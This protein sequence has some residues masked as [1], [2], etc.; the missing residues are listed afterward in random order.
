MGQLNRVSPFK[1]VRRSLMKMEQVDK[2]MERP[3]Y[4]TFPWK[5]WDVVQAAH[6]LGCLQIILIP[7]W[8]DTARTHSPS[9]NHH[10]RDSPRYT[11]HIP[12]QAV[13]PRLLRLPGRRLRGQVLR[14]LSLCGAGPCGFPGSQ[15][16]SLL[17]KAH[18]SFHPDGGDIPGHWLESRFPP[19][20]VSVEHVSERKTQ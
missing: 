18:H 13:V 8:P 14:L 17:S 11:E 20:P 10:N 15:G 1:L 9:S 12:A 6:G 2:D 7:A 19:V 5:L 4:P 3:Q 16:P